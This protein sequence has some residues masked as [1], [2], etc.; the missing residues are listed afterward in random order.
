M[1]IHHAMAHIECIWNSLGS[2]RP[3]MRKLALPTVIASDNTSALRALAQPARQSGQSIIRRT[4]EIARKLRDRGG[5]AIRLQWVPARSEVIGGDMAH[6]LAQDAT[7]KSLPRIRI[8]TL[9]P[10]LKQVKDAIELR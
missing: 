9:A 6:D 5:P 3:D 4:C 10:T 8:T 7:A 1:A 2:F